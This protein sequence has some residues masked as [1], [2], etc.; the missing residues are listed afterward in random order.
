MT[1]SNQKP[2]LTAFAIHLFIS[3]ALLASL[4]FLVYTRWY[5]GIL[6]TIGGTAGIQLVVGVDLV[7][8]PLLT[9]IIFN[10][11]KKK[12]NLLI[13][14][15][16]I[17][18]IQLSAL[19]AGVYIVYNERPLVIVLSDDGLYTH[20]LSEFKGANLD[21]TQLEKLPGDYPKL[22]Y[23]DLPESKEESEAVKFASSFLSSYPATMRTDLY[24]E[25]N[26][27]TLQKAYARLASFDF[28]SA[29]QCYIT[30]ID[31]QHFY[32]NVCFSP[33][34]GVISISSKT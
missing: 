24:M 1:I 9:L 11:T 30:P 19:F 5:P 18:A 16:I 28:D 10:P 6:A 29:Q 4:L 13:D 8:G 31:S 23:L 14:L 20:T 17:G 32:G 12:S 26:N 27:D 34:K 3:G 7:L 2:R 33:E 25:L 22:V 21:L 15:T